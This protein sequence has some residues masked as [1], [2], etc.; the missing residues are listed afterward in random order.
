MI[1]QPSCN[2]SFEQGAITVAAAVTAILTATP[3][4]AEY[5]QRALRDCL[6]GILFEDIRSPCDVPAHNNSAMDGYALRSADLPAASSRSFQVIGTAFAGKPFTSE[7]QQNQCVRIMTGAMVPAS[8]DTIVIQEDVNVLDAEHVEIG[9]GHRKNQNL[10]FAGEDI[11]Q[12]STVLQ[13]GS[14]INAAELGVLASLGINEMTLYRK[15][16]V[17]FFST[18]D[19][20]RSIGETLRS[21]DIYDSNRYSLYGLLKACDVDIIDMGVVRDDPEAIRQALLAAARCSDVVL[22]SGGVS[23]GEADYIK[24]ILQDI[25][26]M[27]FWKILMKPGRPLTSGKINDTLF[28]GLPGNPVAVMVTFYQFVL[29]CLRKLK[30]LP[31]KDV[32]TLKARSLHAIRKNPGRREFQR[33]IASTDAQG[34]LQV[35]LTGK[36]GSG[37]LTSMSQANCFMVLAEECGPVE[38]GSE[39]DI[40][41][42]IHYFD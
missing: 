12:G 9:T 14:R 15:P 29:P 4:I 35:A 32:L 3:V 27:D 31:H 25:G 42:F 41:F 23:V 5:Q 8:T 24:D 20:L 10:R 26:S 33:A 28:F 1:K 40:Q 19:E 37:I 17:S 16:R 22:T 38:A 21:G 18:G 2:D 34:N 6:H 7:C 36:Q 39:V 11:S 30:G 13:K